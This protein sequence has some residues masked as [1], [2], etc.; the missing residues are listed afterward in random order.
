[1]KHRVRDLPAEL[2]QKLDP[3]PPP[4]VVFVRGRTRSVLGLQAAHLGLWGSP[5][6]DN[7]SSRNEM[8]GSARG[9]VQATNIDNVYLGAPEA[10]PA[11]PAQAGAPP[12]PFVNREIP[13]AELRS[14]AEA[15]DRVGPGVAAVR[16]MQGVGKTALLLQFAATAAD[17]FT[18]G[19]LAVGFGPGAGAPSEA[20]WGLLQGLGVPEQRIPA[21]F[22]H[23]VAMYRSMTAGRRLLVLMDDVTDA[24]QV[25][26]L[27]PNSSGS[28]VVVAGNRALEDLLADGALDVP[29]ESLSVDDGVELLRRLCGAQRVD[30]QVEQARELVAAYEGHP[31]A[32]KAA[33][34]RLRLRASW[35]V[36]RLLTELRRAVPANGSVEAKV[37]ESFDQVYGDLPGPVREL[38]RVVGVVIGVRIGVE[39]LAEVTGRPRDDV[40]AD[41]DDLFAVGLV[42]EDREETYRLHRLVRRHALQRTAEEDDDGVRRDWRE[43]AVRWWLAEAVGADLAADPGRLRV[44]D[45]DSVRG[46][47]PGGVSAAEALTWLDHEHANLLAVLDAAAAEGWNAEVCRLF[48]ALFAL[49]KTRKPLSSWVRAGRVA[50]DAAVLTGS[51]ETEAR[52]RCLL[53]KAFQELERFDEAHAQLRRAQELVDDVPERFAASV[54]DFT[55]NLCLRQG[56]PE[57]ALTWFRRAL[58]INRRLGL[59]RGTALQS[60]LAARALGRLGR[61]EEALALFAEARDLVTGG[62]AAVL[63]PK[64]LAGTG[65]VLAAAGRVDEARRA[66]LDAVGQAVE[67]GNTADAT[68][69]LISLA[70]L[71]GPDAD[72]H[73]GQAVRLL[74]QMGSP[75]AARLIAG[76]VQRA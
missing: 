47:R 44:P 7:S 56:D 70:D 36:S 66:L 46:E 58:A 43:R 9:V 21:K 14:R 34:G 68:D 69:A 25:S 19:V 17:L 30:A 51:P 26:A 48:E 1:M 3:T 54:F 64:I 16:G 13:L 2:R 40:A 32:I 53:A 52:C 24:G 65:A 35:P 6:V 61:V 41:L 4:I 8:S 29:L 67:E 62:P 38:Y 15:V 18:D 10:E 49:Y 33:A 50:V 76:I 39:A 75:R 23:R 42:T 45:P 37:L 11:V 55:G 20:A 22:E 73:R 5:A 63:L 74:E 72:A 27:L 28:M 57:T 59:V 60:A 31:S 12:S 71:G